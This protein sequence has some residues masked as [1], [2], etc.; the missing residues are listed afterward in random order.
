MAC[1]GGIKTIRAPTH[2]LIAGSREYITR[3]NFQWWRGW[4]KAIL[5]LLHF[6]SHTEVITLASTTHHP[7]NVLLCIHTTL[8]ISPKAQATT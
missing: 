7:T 3:V 5:G 6:E 8:G 2:Q 1:G 4:R